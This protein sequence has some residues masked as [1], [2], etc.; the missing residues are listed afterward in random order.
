VKPVPRTF[1]TPAPRLSQQGFA[2]FFQGTDE[3]PSAGSPLALSKDAT[4][5]AQYVTLIEEDEPSIKGVG[6]HM[7]YHRTA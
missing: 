3:L 5:Q 1:G 4:D 2:V 7:G 6:R